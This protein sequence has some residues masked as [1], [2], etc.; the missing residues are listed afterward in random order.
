MKNKIYRGKDRIFFGV[1]SGLAEYFNVNP[2]I[3]RILV[4]LICFLTNTIAV[5]IIYT[6]IAIFLRSKNDSNND[7]MMA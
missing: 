4:F 2:A 5:S 1:C 6:L 7:F 3:I